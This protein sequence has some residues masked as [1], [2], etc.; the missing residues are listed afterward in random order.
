M[1]V[2]AVRKAVGKGLRKAREL[3]EAG[4]A[5][6]EVEEEGERPNP[7]VAGDA[8]DGTAS[9]TGPDPADLEGEPA[10]A[11]EADRSEEREG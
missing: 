1:D 2:L 10:A 3:A 11:R 9:R 8:Q 7:A 5:Y 4:A 6:A